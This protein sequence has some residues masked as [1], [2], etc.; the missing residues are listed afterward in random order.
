MWS[1]IAILTSYYGLPIFFIYW[2]T[3]IFFFK[4]PQLIHGKKNLNKRW[5]TFLNEKG[6]IMHI[7]HRGGNPLFSL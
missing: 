3:S 1:F 4:Y 2:L 6:K 7:S 5:A